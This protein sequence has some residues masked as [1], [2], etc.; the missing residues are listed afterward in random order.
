MRVYGTLLVDDYQDPYSIA[1][2][3]LSLGTHGSRKKAR[4]SKQR[5]DLFP[6][7][8]FIFHSI[9]ILGYFQVVASPGRCWLF[10]FEFWFRGFA[11]QIYPQ[12]ID[13]TNIWPTSLGKPPDSVFSYSDH[14]PSLCCHW[15][16]WMLPVCPASELWCFNTEPGAQGTGPMPYFKDCST[17]CLSFEASRS[18]MWPDFFLSTCQRSLSLLNFGNKSR[19]IAFLPSCLTYSSHTS[20]EYLF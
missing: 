5:R 4:F 9:R 8:R 2:S 14:W 17:Y 10:H 16:L 18:Q 13:C 19:G 15:L 7:F 11:L 20:L 6:Q 1:H 12:K 3:P